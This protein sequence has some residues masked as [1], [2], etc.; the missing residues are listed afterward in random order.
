[1]RCIFVLF[2]SLNRRSL[3]PYAKDA[4]PTPNFDRLAQ[5]SVT[6]DTHYV[7]SLPCMPAR[8]ELHTGR[9]NFL[10]RSWGPLEPFDNSYPEILYENGTYSHLV[11]DHCHYFMDGGATYHTRFDSFDYIRGQE[12]DRWK[13][14][15]EATLDRFKEKYHKLQFAEARHNAKLQHMI[16]REFMKDEA[17]FP[18]VQCFQSAFEFLDTNHKADDWLL[19][20]ETFDPHEPFHAPERFREPFKTDYVGPILDWPP[21]AR[22]TEDAAEI[23]ELRANYHAVLALCDELLGKLLDYMDSHNLWDDTALIV[24]TDHGF[25]LGEHDY[26][27][28]NYMP[29]YDE[30]AHIPLFI[31]HPDHKNAAGER[32]RALTQTI[33]LMPTMLEIMGA[34][35]PEHVQGHSLLPVMASDHKIRDVGIYGVYGSAINITDGR[36]TYFHYPPD[37]KGGDLYQYTLMPTHIVRRFSVEELQDLELAAPYSFTKGVK[38][39]KVPTTPKSP[40]FA[41]PMG[42]AT[43]EQHASMIFDTEADPLQLQALDDPG[44]IGRLRQELVSILKASEA[45][46]DLYNRFGLQAA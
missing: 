23:A 17:D 25:L 39:L 43:A 41:H 37:L 32:R 44:Q 46:S 20:L 21:Y 33:D 22:V 36:Y 27:A 30:V 28:K 2:D 13:A 14:M 19:H 16:N 24:T 45:P 5:K 18:S 42:P 15:V 4:P 8:R 26:W 31:H 38:T 35:I 10:H 1:M 6:F 34:P 40:Y 12:K 3:T 7:G 11:T 9:Y 29:C